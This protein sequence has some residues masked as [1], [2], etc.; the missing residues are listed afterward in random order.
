[1]Q[2]RNILGVPDMLLLNFMRFNYYTITEK[3]RICC[4]IHI[5][6]TQLNSILQHWPDDP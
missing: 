3:S 6:N 1:M 2:Q 4:L 5:T